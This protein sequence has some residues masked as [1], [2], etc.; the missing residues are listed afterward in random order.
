MSWGTCMS[1]SNNIHFDFPP[2]MMDGRNFANWQPGSLLNKQLREQAGI[3]TNNDY[4]Q[5]LINNAD[6]IIKNNL[7]QAANECK[8]VLNEDIDPTLNYNH[9]IN[10]PYLYKSTMDKSVPFGYEGSD[11]KNIYLSRQ[12]LQSNMNVP[13]LSQEQLI[14][15]RYSVNNGEIKY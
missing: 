1:G 8:S 14:Q 15:L 11:L 4:R 7:Y 6:K 9:T 12:E 5:F 3:K 2:I 13:L 10:T